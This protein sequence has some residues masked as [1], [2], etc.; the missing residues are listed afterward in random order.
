MKGHDRSS[1]SVERGGGL[2]LVILLGGL[3]SAIGL[4][5]VS[6]SLTERALSANYQAG[7]QLLYAAEAMAHRLVVD[8]S[9]AT[10]WP[11]ALAGASSSA[12][13]GPLHPTTPW[14][15]LLDLAALTAALQASSGSA[16]GG[17]VWRLYASG[18]FDA[19]TG[20]ASA[21]AFLIGWVADDP[22]DPDGDP[23][24]DAN[25]AIVVRAEA[26]AIGGMRRAVQLVLRYVPPPPP[27]EGVPPAPPAETP[28]VRAVSWREVR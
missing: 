4:A 24:A 2:L 5:L 9:S 22:A 3:L 26:R 23:G 12:F 14:G 6:L 19:L 27:V 16:G 10:D 8:L 28:G 13:S 1:D 25:N 21:Q 11:Q 7:V 17:S 18:P 15:E 20:T